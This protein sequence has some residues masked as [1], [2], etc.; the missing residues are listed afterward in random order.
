M[1]IMKII[2][3]Y[4]FDGASLAPGIHDNNNNNKVFELN[5]NRILSFLIFDNEIAFKIER[6]SGRSS[7]PDG[8]L[9]NQ[10]GFIEY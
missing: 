7:E 3:N 5:F 2:Q 1:F 4:R 9:T 6:K 10:M 8:E